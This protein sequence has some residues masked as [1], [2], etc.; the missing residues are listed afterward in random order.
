MNPVRE[1]F[2]KSERLCS[3]KLITAL[4]SEGN[5]FYSPLFKIVWLENRGPLPY[6]AQVAFSVSKKGFRNA[7]TRNLL[8][9]RTREAYRKNKHDF[10]EFLNS[11]NIQVAFIIIFREN[12]VHDFTFIEK[13]VKEMLNKFTL[14]ISEKIKKC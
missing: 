14:A 6:P 4:F 8:K 3:R 10:Y 5:V 12:V 2:H 13:S 9:R 1:T 7:V 11:V